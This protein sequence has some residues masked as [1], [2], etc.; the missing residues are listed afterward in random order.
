MNELEIKFGTRK[1][2]KTTGGY[3]INIPAVM[4]KT[5]DFNHG[6]K[7]AVSSTPDGTITIKKE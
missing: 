1:L 2:Q 4:M 6:D 5:F 7:F 3:T